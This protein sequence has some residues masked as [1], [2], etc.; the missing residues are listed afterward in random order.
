MSETREEKIYTYQRT[1]RHSM[2]DRKGTI[3][4]APARALA[5]HL[6]LYLDDMEACWSIGTEWL[7]ISLEA[8]RVDGG[9]A[10]PSDP[11]YYP[12][13]GESLSD[14][15]EIPSLR[16]IAVDNADS[17]VRLLWKSM[18]PV[19][20]A[21]VSEERGFGAKLRSDLVNAGITTKMATALRSRTGPFA[22]LCADRV[23]RGPRD[24]SVDQYETFR[25]VSEEVLRPVLGA[26]L[27]LRRN[28][29]DP[30][31]IL[32]E[33]L[34]DAELR[35]AQLTALGLSYKQ[36]ARE[37]DRSFHTI[38]H[39]LRSIR[40]KLGI[41][42]HAKLARYLSHQLRD[43]DNIFMGSVHRTDPDIR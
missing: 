27:E 37:L 43:S 26:A 2:L 31:A 33:Q 9:Y 3:E 12:G 38:D 15:E 32:R 10:I 22:L 4:H 24:W 8:E 40:I 14:I 16:G 41:E 34:S 42:S 28:A 17:G 6:L 25:S 29:K 39:Q 13:Q 11:A 1:L 35:V 20:F 18:K 19:V 23:K 5:S 30:A 21:S 36:I 7:R